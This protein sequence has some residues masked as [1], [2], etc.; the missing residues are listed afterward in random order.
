[1]IKKC[2]MRCHFGQ[3]GQQY[4]RPVAVKEVQVSPRAHVFDDFNKAP[5]DMEYL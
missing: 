1:M 2:C 4:K 5:L 3:K